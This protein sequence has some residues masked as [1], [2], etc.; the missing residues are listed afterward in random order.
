MRILGIE[1]SCDETGIAIYDEEQGILSHRLYSQIK[2]HADYGGVVPELAS[3]DHVRKTI[4]LVKEVLADAK[5][6]PQDLDG[7]AYTAGPGL[8]GALLVGCSIGRSLAY[9]WD[10]PAVP[11]H[12]MEGHLLAPMLEETPPEFPFVALLVSGGH[13]MLV[14]VDGIGEY[15]MLG[16][17]VDDA[18]GEAFDKTAK[19]LGLDYPGGPVLAKMAEQGTKG[20]FK[21]PRPM[22]DRPG[23]DF[24]FSGLKTFAANTIHKEVHEGL[25][26]EQLAQTH[27]DIAYAFQEAVVDTLSIKCKRALEHCG[28]NR[29]VIAGG[30]SANT[31]LREKLAV[32]AQKL[33][34]N[35]F[36]P[37][38][39]F[40]TD[41]GAM[42]AYAGMQR[43]KAGVF[44]DLTFKAKP[45]WPLDTLPPVK[46]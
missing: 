40:C 39:E 15:E 19:L 20:R 8:V 17:S 44:A 14:R 29:L 25:S 42:I 1:T 9:G 28:L 12:H 46:S 10:L 11:V 7:V 6:T 21:F 35:V 36:Y 24:S 38:P 45:R 41:N 30:V 5:L 23:L 4:P 13:T 2:V 37:R 18:A 26:A 43:L 32:T 3:R 16:E 31:S 22:T 33:G 34:G 27:A